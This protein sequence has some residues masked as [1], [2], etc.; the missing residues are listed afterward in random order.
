HRDARLAASLTLQAAMHLHTLELSANLHD[1]PAD[2][3][4]V[5]VELGLARAPGADAAAQTLEVGPL[6]DQSRQEI[7]ELRQLDLQLALGGAR[8]LGEDVEDQCGP[9]DDLDAERLGDIALL[10]RRELVVGDEEIGRRRAGGRADLLDLAAPEVERG[11]WRRPLLRDAADDRAAGRHHQPRQLLDRLVGFRAALRRP[12]QRADHGALLTVPRAVSRSP[13]RRAR[14]RSSW[15]AI[16]SATRSAPP[17]FS[18]SI[19]A[20]SGSRANHVHWRLAYRT[21]SRCM[22]RSASGTESAPRATCTNSR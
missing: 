14:L 7:R 2:D 6:P 5:G 12:P 13:H 1:L 9:V 4:P 15:G 22:R 16:S 19:H 21:V 3:P 10:D 18:M 20:I 8:A 11:R 17:S